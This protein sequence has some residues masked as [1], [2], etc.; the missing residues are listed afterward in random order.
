MPQQTKEAAIS[1]RPGSGS[2]DNEITDRRLESPTHPTL[3]NVEFNLQ[4]V[5]V[6]GEKKRQQV[7]WGCGII[8]DSNTVDGKIY[9]PT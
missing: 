8:F 3:L 4:L 2:K 6:D 7:T 1:T 5:P 9:F